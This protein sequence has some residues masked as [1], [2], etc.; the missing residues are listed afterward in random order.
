MPF[1]RINARIEAAIRRASA[2]YASAKYYFVPP[3]GPR[4]ELTAVKR[5]AETDALAPISGVASAR[6]FEFVVARQSFDDAVRALSASPNVPV[7]SLFDSFRK[8][9]VVAVST[10]GETTTFN[11]DAARPIQENSPDGG[12]VRFFVYE[13]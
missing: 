2:R 8:S 13:V 3:T 12:S 6:R 4:V 9:S 7:A 10:T 5:D 11:F 1:S